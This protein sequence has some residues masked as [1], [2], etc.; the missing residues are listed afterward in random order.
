MFI[1]RINKG[2]NLLS[3]INGNADGKIEQYIIADSP[4]KDIEKIAYLAHKHMELDEECFIN[5]KFDW[6]YGQRARVLELVSKKDG[7][8][9]IYKMVSSS[10]FDKHVLDLQRIKEEIH[11]KYSIP[12]EKIKCKLVLQS[13]DNIEKLKS[14]LFAMASDFEVETF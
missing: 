6:A 13:K 4:K 8:I 10:N 12:E 3:I 5:V 11:H 14:L 2:S 9:T 1:R 7:S